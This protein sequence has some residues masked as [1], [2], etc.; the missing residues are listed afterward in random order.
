MRL[1]RP[2]YS[3][4]L[5]ALVTVFSISTAIAQ[6]K[7]TGRKKE[8]PKK[9]V[10]FQKNLI[11]NAL[12]FTISSPGLDS[13]NTIT[14]TPKGLKLENK[15]ITLSITGKL[16]DVLLGDI[17]GDSWPE[18]VLWETS[19]DK[20]PSLIHGYTV[21]NGLS[22]TAFNTTSLNMQDGLTDGRMGNDEYQIGNN[23]LMYRFPLF[24]GSKRTGKT[25][26]LQYS[27]LTTDDAKQLWFEKSM[28]Y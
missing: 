9:P 27:L 16:H 17:D 3:L 26:Q 20:S 5:V 24:K 15:S 12:N 21:N 8:L 28:D 23:V 14:I 1:I 7:S 10:P 25:R 22:F 18:M 4:L 19:S 2:V 6:E 11:Y 13:G